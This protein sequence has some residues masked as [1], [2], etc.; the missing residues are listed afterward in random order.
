MVGTDPQNVKQ[1]VRAGLRKGHSASADGKSHRP[2][3]K[4][5]F[6]YTSGQHSNWHIGGGFYENVFDK[7]EAGEVIKSRVV[8]SDKAPVKGVDFIKDP[9]SW[10]FETRPRSVVKNLQKE[11]DAIE[12]IRISK[13]GNDNIY[14]PL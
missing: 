8:K 9:R 3:D 5:R 12:E 13:D 1:E 4:K 6:G 11:R 7:N 2:G 14:L 10:P